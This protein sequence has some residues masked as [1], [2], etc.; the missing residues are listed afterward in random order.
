MTTNVLTKTPKLNISDNRLYAFSGKEINPSVYVCMSTVRYLWHVPKTVKHIQLVAYAFN[1]E[2]SYE[3][4]HHP[5][6]CGELL[7][8]LLSSFL[9]KTVHVHDR[10][11]DLAEQAFEER[12]RLRGF[13]TPNADF[14]FVKL[15]YWT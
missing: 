1:Y 2:D 9:W 15:F 7:V 3:V 14:C 11:L 12:K 5:V 13:S 10:L 6:H 8:I 4:A